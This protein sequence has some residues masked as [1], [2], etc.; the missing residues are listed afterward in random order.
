MKIIEVCHRIYPSYIGGVEKVVSGISQHLAKRFEIEVYTTN[1]S[2]KRMYKFRYNNV[3]ITEFPSTA[4][5]EILYF[6]PSLY[7]ALK[8]VNADV[9]HAHGCQQ[10]TSFAAALAKR[11]NG[12]PLLVT[13]HFGFSEVPRYAFMIYNLIVN[14]LIFNRA[15]KIVAISPNEIHTIRKIG[16]FDEKILYIPNG[17]DVERIDLVLNKYQRPIIPKTVLYVGRLEEKKGLHFLVKAFS[18]IS[19]DVKLNIVGDGTYRRELIKLV[20]NL[21]LKNKVRIFG[22]V[23][24]SE[25][26][27]LYATAHVF[28]LLSSHESHSMALTEAMAFGLVPVVTNVGGNRYIVSNYENGFLVSYPVSINEVSN[29]LCKLVRDQNLIDLISEKARKTVKERFNIELTTKLLG[30]VYESFTRK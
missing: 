16:N 5:N 6:S 21:K 30:D 2:R 15:D 10:F 3:R 12:I 23:S 7:S 29:V 4:P 24:D 8:A 19:E 26:E 18:R 13:P 9:I 11:R 14:K 28:V 25:L 27:Q 17:V 1:P 20:E 22:R